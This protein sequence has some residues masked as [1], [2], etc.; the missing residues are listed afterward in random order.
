MAAQ[1]D[2]FTFAGL[3]G[4][5]DLVLTCTGGL[6]RNRAVGVE[7]GRGRTIDEITA[8]MNMVAEGVKTTA[9]VRQLSMRA[10]VEMPICDQMYEVLYEAK[11]PIVAARDLMGRALRSEHG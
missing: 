5:G 2:T 11:S 10:G 7:L 4:M 3:S 1:H 6:S 8:D 9:A